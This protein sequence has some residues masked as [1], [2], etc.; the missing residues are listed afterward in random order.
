MFLF[1][2]KKSRKRQSQKSKLKKTNHK[3]SESKNKLICP[4]PTFFWHVFRL[5]FFRLDFDCVWRFST[6]LFDF[7]EW[8]TLFFDFWIRLVFFY[9]CWHI[10]STFFDFVLTFSS[11][12][13]WL[14]LF[15]LYV[16]LFFCLFLTL[17]FPVDFFGLVFDLFF[18]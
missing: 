8:L 12:G 15:W 6:F 16:C 17:T 13:L 11:C 2:S 9:L 4:D 10:F 5:C 1:K 18:Y 3:I 14:A 7:F